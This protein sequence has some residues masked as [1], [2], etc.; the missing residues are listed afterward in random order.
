MNTLS[1]N[2]LNS[3]IPKSQNVNV[4][5]VI[6]KYVS[7]WPWFFLSICLCLSIGYLYLQFAT[8]MF[9]TSARILVNDDKKG[10]SLTAGTG[11]LSDL[12][13]LFGGKST[14][15]NEVE[16]LKT[17]YLLDRVVR[18]LRLNITYSKNDGFRDVEVYEA[19]FTVKLLTIKDTITSATMEIIML[20][21]GKLSYSAEGEHNIVS[22]NQPFFLQ[23]VGY[24]E[25]NR[26]NKVPPKKDQ[27]TIRIVSARGKTTELTNNL[28][29]TVSNKLVSII[30][31]T[32][33]NPVPERGEDILN[34]L[35]YNYVQQN[36]SEK[37]EVADST[38]AFI[39]RRLLIIGSE[40]GDAE[41]NIQGFKQKNSLADMTEQGKLLVSSS[42]QY[43]S[44][45]AKIETQISII[46]SVINYLRDNTINKRVLPS[47][48][49][50]DN[51]TFSEAVQKYNDLLLERGRSLIGLTV[52]NPVIIN[53]DKQI[54]NSRKDIEANLEST[55]SGLLITRTRI[56]KQMQSADGQIRQV[57]AT[58]R[59]YLKLA[60]Q[61]QIKQELYIFLMQKSEE[62]A[63]SKTANIA[64]SRTIDP[65]YSDQYAFSPKKNVVYLLTF[66]IGALIPM[67]VLYTM[68]LLNTKVQS[69]A[70]IVERTSAAILG[71]IS[72]NLD[73][74]SALINPNSRSV[75]SEQ[76]RALRTNLSFYLKRND[77]KIILL[78][79]S[80][81][82][83][84]KSFV[85]INLGNVLAISGKKVVLMELDLR[86][87]SLSTKLDQQ[88]I[89]GFTN[90]IISEEMELNTIIKPLKINPNLYLISSGPIPPNPAEILMSS[91]TE[92]VLQRLKEEFDF[93]IID[94][95]PIGIV[96]DA[97]VL[98][99]F[100]DL[101]IYLVR[102]DYTYKDQITIIDDLLQQKKM[103]QI[104][105]VIND[106][107]ASVSYGG[108]YGY[109]YGEYFND[110][111][112]TG[113]HNRIK[114]KSTT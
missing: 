77:E 8:P 101:C 113:I 85:A 16:I 24:V 49:M 29:V 3:Q 110:D 25:I 10:G 44:D 11:A 58:E 14:V 97:Q 47:T 75:I 108:G 40:L 1:D 38:I 46:K 23:G 60:R 72:H 67:F 111:N 43:V 99:N 73:S 88:N 66:L 92:K 69:K 52:N 103:R 94:A 7:K 89:S 55:L 4:W 57:P 61:Q 65:P 56:N 37:N 86:K 68:D 80:M 13:N 5:K 84:G 31:L 19:P 39:K 63:I 64:N 15:D 95:P 70:D 50:P 30:D 28:S 17:K 98:A 59:N 53:L 112:R 54:V 100:A 22:F 82:G 104:G 36:L 83:E 35:I 102:Q 41:T 42:S 81:S 18:D 12:G 20:S 32:L 34:R 62:T 76:F 91:R 93:I 33:N 96:T 74:Q 114:V 9:K 109:G 78:T 79:S 107:K 105:I 51:M 21:N 87:P 106:I 71:E 6:I 2:Q 45:L 90:Y 27:Y 48:L 26:N